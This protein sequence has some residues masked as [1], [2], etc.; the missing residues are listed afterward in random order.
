MRRWALMRARSAA[1]PVLRARPPRPTARDSLPKRFELGARLLRAIRITALLCIFDRLGE[2]GDAL[3][4]RRARTFVE[5]FAGIS[6]IAPS[7]HEL[8]RVNL[9][10]GRRDEPRDHRQSTQRRHHDVATIALDP[11]RRS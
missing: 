2:L 4:I 7:T 5:R 9:C 8:E 6:R 1:A 10:I 3:A 11:P